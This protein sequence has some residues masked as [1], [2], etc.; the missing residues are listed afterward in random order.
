MYIYIIAKVTRYE[1]NLLLDQ[2]R[3]LILIIM[4]SL[5]SNKTVYDVPMQS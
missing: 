5:Q 1:L 4:L 3:Y 2:A